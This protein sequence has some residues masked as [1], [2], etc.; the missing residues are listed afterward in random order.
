MKRIL[1]LLLSLLLLTGC[2][3]NAADGAYQQITQEEAKEM[4]DSQEVIIHSLSLRTKQVYV[5]I[6]N[7]HVPL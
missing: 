5:S 4:M 3:G 2:G 1:P 7:R 6:V